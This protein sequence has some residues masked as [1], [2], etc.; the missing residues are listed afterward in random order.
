VNK[1]GNMV[2][3]TNYAF[4]FRAMLT[5]NCP[6][7]T[8]CHPRGLA[9]WLAGLLAGWRASLLAGWLAGLLS[10]LLAGWRAG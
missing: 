6:V 10:G 3:Y 2:P 4:L 7:R 9:G 8:T 1:H 5:G